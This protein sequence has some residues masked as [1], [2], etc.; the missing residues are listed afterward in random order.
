[1]EPRQSPRLPDH[2]H[3]PRRASAIVKHRA[4]DAHAPD[5]ASAGVRGGI[6]K[7]ALATEPTS[8][9]NHTT[10]DTL[11]A[12]TMWHVYET[13]FTYDASFQAVPLLA[14]AHEVSRDGLTHR[15]RSGRRSASTTVRS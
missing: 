4:P 3:R 5:G 12:M 13:L 8:L 2:G 11:V 10:T 7:V 1:M 14:H 9:D 15:S 6:L